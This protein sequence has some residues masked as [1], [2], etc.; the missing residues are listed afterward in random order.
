[1]ST[2]N[3]LFETGLY[4]SQ[5]NDKRS[6]M[7]PGNMELAAI[8]SLLPMMATGSGEKCSVSPVPEWRWPA[9]IDGLIHVSMELFAA[10]HVCQLK[11]REV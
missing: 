9:C 5:V 7:D 3:Q 6:R 4:H 1:M 10:R 8:F 2:F 11:I